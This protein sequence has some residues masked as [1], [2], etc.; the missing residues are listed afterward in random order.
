MRIA[1]LS[2]HKASYSVQRIKEAGSALDHRIRILNPQNFIVAIAEGKPELY[3][4]D[5]KLQLPDAVIPRIAANIT[6]FG[7]SVLRQFEQMGVFTVNTSH[8]V[9]TSRDKLRAL[10][11]LSRHNIGVT[12]T[13][14]V[15][16]LAA[17]GKSIERLG[18]A[19]V[20]IKTVQ[21]TQ[22]TG[23]MLAETPKSAEAI[24]EALQG[25]QQNVLIQ[26]FVS[27]SRGRDIRAFVVGGKVVAAMRRTAVGDEFR[28]NVHRGGKTEGLR[29]TKDFERTA[30][31]A[32]QVLGLRIA[33]VDLLETHDG[34]QV[35]EVNSSPGL[36]GIE[37]ATGVDIARAIIEH[38]V[39]QVKFLEVDVKQEPIATDYG[40]VELPVTRM[41]RGLRIRESVLHDQNVQVLRIQRGAETIPS[42]SIDIR[43]QTGDELLCYGSLTV[44]KNLIPEKR[45]RPR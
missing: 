23:V 10:Q 21:G 9:L 31:R 32:A 5:K 8:S 6:F 20:V 35:M 7:T 14:I 22:G 25:A 18:G 26:K 44:L 37:K 45:R 38:T 39:D 11:V 3:Y 1:I 27:E 24:V 28:S 33:G 4:K 12:P 36:E 15:H 13:E 40:L 19:P 29:L 16:D 42:P 17:I 30:I 43:L 34:P 2:Q 41:L